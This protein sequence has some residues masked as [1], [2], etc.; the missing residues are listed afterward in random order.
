MSKSNSYIEKLREITAGLKAVGRN[1]DL[2]CLS[3]FIRSFVTMNVEGGKGQIKA[4][5]VYSQFL[6]VVGKECPCIRKDIEDM[7][8]I[9]GLLAFSN[10]QNDLY[11]L[12]K[13]IKESYE[14]E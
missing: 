13:D 14:G 3:C 10:E 1:Y 9:N 5:E 4:L 11:Q 6:N 2:R 12:Y 7:V 8:I